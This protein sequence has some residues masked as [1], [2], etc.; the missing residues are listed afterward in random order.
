[1]AGVVVAV[2]PTAGAREVRGCCR[3]L[4][5]SVGSSVQAAHASQSERGEVDES[6]LTICIAS[7]ERLDELG[8]SVEERSAE[9][10]KAMT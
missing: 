4:P 8:Y 9:S 7:C 10:R 1:M 3:D 2:P 5:S 6:A